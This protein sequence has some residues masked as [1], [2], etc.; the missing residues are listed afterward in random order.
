MEGR[1]WGRLQLMLMAVRALDEDIFRPMR[2]RVR[3][4]IQESLLCK[5]SPMMADVVPSVAEA[6][7]RGRGS[8]YR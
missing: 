5:R 1:N 6:A 3:S 7:H 4:R 2:I 8:A